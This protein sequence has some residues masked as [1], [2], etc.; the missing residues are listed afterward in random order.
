MSAKSISGCMA[1]WFGEVNLCIAWVTTHSLSEWTFVNK[2][3][4]LLH[5][6]DI[7]NWHI[8]WISDR[9]SQTILFSCYQELTF[10]IWIMLLF[11]WQ[12]VANVTPVWKGGGAWQS[13]DCMYHCMTISKL[14][15]NRPI[16][17]CTPWTCKEMN[18]KDQRLAASDGVPGFLHD[19]LEGSRTGISLDLI[20]V[21][22]LLYFHSFLV[23]F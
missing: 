6:L 10:G 3:H 4:M 5:G 19:A 11:S 9:W 20:W 17:L 12:T 14:Y 2:V 15:R 8:L 7:W 1:G 23:I 13:M 21:I 16:F 22:H 18:K